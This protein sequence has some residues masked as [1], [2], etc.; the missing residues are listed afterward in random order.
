MFSQITIM[1]IDIINNTKY[2]LTIPCKRGN[3]LYKLIV[4]YMCYFYVNNVNLI[5]TYLV[6]KQL[7]YLFHKC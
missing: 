7:F 3:Y 4:S 5:H 1:Y 2:T 6:S